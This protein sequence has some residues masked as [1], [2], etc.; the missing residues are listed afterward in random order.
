VKD[1][2]PGDRGG[3]AQQIQVIGK[4]PSDSLNPLYIVDG[5]IM[6]AYWSVNAIPSEMVSSINVI[7]SAPA[8]AAYGEKGRH[9]AVLVTTKDPGHDWSEGES[10]GYK[11]VRPVGTVTIVGQSNGPLFLINGK[12]VPEDTLQK[13]NP[14]SIG[15]INVLKD[16]ANLNSP[17]Y[18]KYGDRA[19]NGVVII[20]MKGE[21]VSYC[22][23]DGRVV[24]WDFV[25]RM[26]A[27]EIESMN[28]LKPDEGLAKYGEKG[29][30]GVVLVT[31]R[32][33]GTGTG[34]Q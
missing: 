34:N 28:V 24:S 17:V 16:P 4:S 2:V 8:I 26:N 19:K 6:P 21:K 27:G 13:I 22:L 31:L 25:Q 14:D 9:G 20:H 32:P 29:K 3:A 10:L 12:E 11:G 15:S 33:K 30:N 7:G 18:A 5:K 1:T 23:V